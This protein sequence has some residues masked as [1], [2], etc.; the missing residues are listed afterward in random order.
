[1]YSGLPSIANF[2]LQQNKTHTPKINRCR[3]DQE[4]I[5]GHCGFTEQTPTPSSLVLWPW[6]SYGTSPTL[7]SLPGNQSNQGLTLG[8]LGSFSNS[9]KAATVYPMLPTHKHS[10]TCLTCLDH[11][12]HNQP[13]KVIITHFTR[14]TWSNPKVTS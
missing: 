2:E 11:S 14:S 4:E 10:P 6:V 7:S 5:A 9:N 13:C 12:I 1:M 8:L 3:W